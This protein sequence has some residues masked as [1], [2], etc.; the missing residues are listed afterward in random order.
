MP[1]PLIKEARA[2]ITGD[3]RYSLRQAIVALAHAEDRSLTSLLEEAIQL[4]LDARE[5]QS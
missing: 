2:K 3:V 5:A 1:R 4:L